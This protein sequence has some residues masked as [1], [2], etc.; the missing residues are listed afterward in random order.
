MRTT[1]VY[2]ENGF[3]I[4]EGIKDS[5][6]VAVKEGDD[7]SFLYDGVSI[8]AEVKYHNGLFIVVSPENN[9]ISCMLSVL[10]TYTDSFTIVI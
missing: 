4:D 2:D 10:N 3:M 1:I 9:P 8:I 6:G 7:L 5:T